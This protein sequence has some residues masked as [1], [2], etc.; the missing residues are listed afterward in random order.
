LIIV[1]HL[2]L[3]FFIKDKLLFTP[4][5]DRSDAVHFNLSLKYFLSKSL[6]QNTLPFWTDALQG[7]FPLFAEG[8]IGALFLPNIVFFRLLGFATAYNLLFVFSLFLMTLGIFLFM[9]KQSIRPLLALFLSYTFTFS[10]AIGFRWIHLNVIQTASLIPLLFFMMFELQK[11]RKLR[12][13]I[14][15][16]F[17]LSQMIFAGHMQIVFIALFGLFLWYIGMSYTLIHLFAVVISGTIISL[18]QLLP[19]FELIRY[20]VRNLMGGY[21]HATSFSMPWSHLL[22]FLFPYPFGNPKRGSYPE[23][24]SNMGI[25]WENTPYIGILFIVVFVSCLIYLFFKKK[26]NKEISVY[27]CIVF[28]FILISLGKNSPVYFLFDIFPFNVFRTPPKYL[29][30]AVFFSVIG[31]G[32]IIEKTLLVAKNS[33][34]RILIMAALFINIVMLGI[35][36]LNYHIFIKNKIVLSP[37]PLTTYLSKDT[38]YI[39]LGFD[40][41]W[42][43][44]F[45]KHGWMTEKDIDMYSFL[46]N[47]LIPNSNLIFGYQSSTI[48]SGGLRLK[49]VEYLTDAVENMLVFPSTEKVSTDSAVKLLSVMG[50]DSIVS[51]YPL[52]Q[53]ENQIYSITNGGS[54]IYL[55]RISSKQETP[56]YVPSKLKKIEYID[57]FDALLEAGQISTVEAVLE[58]QN[59]LSQETHIISHNTEQTDT[60][61]I[62]EVYVPKNTFIVF[63]KNWYPGWTI[64]IDGKRTVGKRVNL[65]HIGVSVPSGRHKITLTYS[66]T[67]FYLGVLLGSIYVLIF[68]LVLVIYRKIKTQ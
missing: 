8:Q 17:F 61:L 26:L 60:K 34:L 37:P 56:Y 19:T 46:N 22:S 35:V 27:L 59:S 31:A 24:P 57:E 58:E 68:P 6:A 62:A 43:S 7:G 15:S 44:Y 49:R 52:L 18:P 11:T 36:T 9:K 4:D 2:I 51:L 66:P 41:V 29:L 54:T 33:F 1:T 3:Y 32:L 23:F 63:R 45:A 39:T 50:V 13:G 20:S 21:A 30:I 48:N 53:K 14:W 10:G 25:F 16:I 40:K 65:I 47:S 28:I 67:S 5:F 64:Q 12:Y 55:Y 42:H 38:R